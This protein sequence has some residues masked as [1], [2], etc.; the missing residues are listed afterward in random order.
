[1]NQL[2]TQKIGSQILRE[3]S[4]IILN[5]AKDSILKQVSITSVEVSR[6]LSHAKVFFTSFND[7]SHD[8]ME[9]ELSEAAPFIRSE[10]AARIDLRHTPAL[11]FKYDDSIAYGSKIEK[12]IKEINKQ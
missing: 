5:E 3:I 4:A 10:L 11:T 9:K 2:K 8:R 6:D 12:I 7:Y 1:M